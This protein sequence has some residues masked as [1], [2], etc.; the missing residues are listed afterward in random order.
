MTDKFDAGPYWG[1]SNLPVNEMPAS[2]L[3]PLTT[4][5]WNLRQ[6]EVDELRA[7][8]Q[9]W[10]DMAQKANAG[11]DALGIQVGKLKR[12]RD[13]LCAQ[14][15]RLSDNSVRAADR[16]KELRAEVERLRAKIT[17]LLTED[18]ANRAESARLKV[19]IVGLLHADEDAFEQAGALDQAG[20]PLQQLGQNPD[21]QD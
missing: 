14:V 19:L 21:Q 15:E 13:E 2:G 3:D 4:V 8:A 9:G 1:N 17:V 11:A 20:D 12:E 10:Y 16:I 6:K 18:S 5:G 7:A